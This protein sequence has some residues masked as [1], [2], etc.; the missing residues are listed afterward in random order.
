MGPPDAEGRA[1]CSAAWHPRP[2]D[3]A[4]KRPLLA[5]YP[6]WAARGPSFADVE[7]SL[8]VWAPCN[9]ALVAVGVLV[10]IEADSPDADAELASLGGAELASAPAREARSGRGRAYVFRAPPGVN[11][12]NGARRGTSGAVDVRGTG[13]LLVVPPSR[14]VS[15]HVYAWLPGRAVGDCAA[16]GARRTALAARAADSQASAC[17][18]G[19]GRRRHGRRLDHRRG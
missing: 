17:T 11:V 19:S 13:G 15:G 6:R 3:R 12:P 5:D 10:V 14:H 2:C 1:P 7:S 4:G 16:G 9:L 18:H 8:R